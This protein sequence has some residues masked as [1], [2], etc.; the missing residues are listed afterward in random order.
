MS[1]SYKKGG[2]FGEQAAPANVDS[3]TLD[4]SQAP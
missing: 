3:D 4:M 2:G 1:S